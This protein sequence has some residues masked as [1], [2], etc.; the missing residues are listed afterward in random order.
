VVP[1]VWQGALE[2]EKDRPSIATS[3]KQKELEGA[4]GFASKVDLGG[5]EFRV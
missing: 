3:L 4:S 5:N 2:I 1:E